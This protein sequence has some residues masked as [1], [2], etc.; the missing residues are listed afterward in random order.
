MCDC[1]R[2]YAWTVVMCNWSNSKSS[3]CAILPF[4]PNNIRFWCRFMWLELQETHH[5]SNRR[6]FRR[7]V[8][9]RCIHVIWCFVSPSHSFRPGPQSK[10]DT[11][12][13]CM[14]ISS[15]TQRYSPM[16]IPPDNERS[17]RAALKS[18]EPLANGK[19][20]ACA[21]YWILQSC[22]IPENRLWAIIPLHVSLE[23]SI[24]HFSFTTDTGAVRGYTP[25]IISNII[26]R[27]QFLS[28]LMSPCESEPTSTFCQ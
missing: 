5:I 7:M 13:R 10:I 24:C 23:S 17:L 6:K 20:H 11:L 26:L 16:N 19:A 21:L 3:R 14:I 4:V 8:F 28:Q 25:K 12:L 18:L 22:G 9:F 15:M 1:Q 2:R 27:Y